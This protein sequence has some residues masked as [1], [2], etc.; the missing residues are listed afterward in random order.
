MI[1]FITQFVNIFYIFIS[2]HFI[3]KQMEE[4]INKFYSERIY[5]R[6]TTKLCEF[7]NA[8]GSDKGTSGGA[9]NYTKLYNL[10]FKDIANNIKNVF[11]VGLGSNNIDVP[12]NMGPNGI[13]G[14][15]LRAWKAYF[16][17]AKIYG[18]DIDNKI[19]FEEERIRTF[20]V[21]QYDENSIKDLWNNF[22]GIEFD[23]M[24][25]DGIHDVAW[26][27]N[28]GNI[29]FFKNSIHKLKKSGFYIIEDVACDHDGEIVSPKVLNFIKDL[30]S[31]VY[32]IFEFAELIK[33]PAFKNKENF[34]NTQLILIKK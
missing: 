23:I 15:S 7:M 11:E 26:T 18:A 24:L 3:I 34:R 30:K 14:A 27:D 12:S 20:F 9:G 5:A 10:L 19:L 13:P 8:Y 4:L 16:P 32:G 17:N 21:D 29:N 6:S 2:C 33:T 1:I 28:S 22:E 25:D 31:G